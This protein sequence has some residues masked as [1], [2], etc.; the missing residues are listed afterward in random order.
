M[1]PPPRKPF[2]GATRSNTALYNTRRWRGLR[3]EVIAENPFC[4]WCK[5]NDTLTV[6]HIENPRGNEALFFNK[7]NLQVLC[8]ACQRIKTAQEIIERKNKDR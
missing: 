5:R 4:A 2:E 8:K 1:K 6:D 3:A 7:D